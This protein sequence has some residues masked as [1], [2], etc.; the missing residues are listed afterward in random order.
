M[1]DAH[2]EIEEA[3][4]ARMKLRHPEIK[5]IGVKSYAHGWRCHQVW[6]VRGAPT[7]YEVT[8][9]F[10][11]VADAILMRITGGLNDPR[12]SMISLGARSRGGCTFES[13]WRE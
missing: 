4:T 6:T 10:L 11:A 13:R 7:S 9:K 1:R 3:V 2:I 8:D 12:S 5:R